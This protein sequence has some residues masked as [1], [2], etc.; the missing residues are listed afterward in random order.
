MAENSIEML[1]ALI[2]P[3]RLKSLSEKT[4]VICSAEP[5]NPVIYVSDAFETHTGYPRE[6][7]IGRNLSLL[8]GPDT[9]PEAVDQFR[10]LIS[11]KKAGTVQIT[12]YRRDGSRFLHECEFRPVWASQDVVSHFVAVQR[13]V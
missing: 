10:Y 11:N 12:N 5:G 8:Q 3:E 4:A 6:E 1:R 2:A 7:L 13:L 9:E